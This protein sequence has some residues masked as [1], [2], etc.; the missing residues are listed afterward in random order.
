MDT[1]PITNNE[2]WTPIQIAG[3][4]PR[5]ELLVFAVSTKE[6][7]SML[8]EIYHTSQFKVATTS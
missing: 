5:K 7:K 2:E 6:S 3:G 4:V 8:G 1:K